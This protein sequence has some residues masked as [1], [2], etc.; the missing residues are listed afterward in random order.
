MDHNQEMIEATWCEY[1]NRYYYAHNHYRVRDFLLDVMWIIL[2][3]GLWV[4]YI[5]VREMRNR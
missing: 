5:F 3:G 1:C 2:T 4:V